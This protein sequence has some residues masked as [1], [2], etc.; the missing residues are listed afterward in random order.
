MLFGKA[1]LPMDLGTFDLPKGGM[2]LAQTIQ[3]TNRT[4]SLR[5]ADIKHINTKPIK[6]QTHR[7]KHNSKLSLENRKEKALSPGPTKPQFIS[8]K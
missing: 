7:A 3:N 4:N 5:N 1:K 2:N 8:V 6:I